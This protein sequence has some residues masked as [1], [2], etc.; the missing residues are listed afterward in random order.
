MKR[1]FAL[2]LCVALCGLVACDD[3]ETEPVVPD[4]PNQENPVP[5]PEPKPEPEPEPL[6]TEADYEFRGNLHASIFL[7]ETNGLRNDY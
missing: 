1:F 2:F 3:K 6:P 5:D 4:N 7:L